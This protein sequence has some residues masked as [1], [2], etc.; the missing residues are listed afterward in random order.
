MPETA[1]GLFFAEANVTL[2]GAPNDT[3]ISGH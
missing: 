3:F 1:L 2:A